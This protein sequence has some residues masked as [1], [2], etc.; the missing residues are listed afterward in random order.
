MDMDAGS[1]NV[2]PNLIFKA[3]LGD[4][5]R[6]GAHA[7]PSWPRRRRV[8]H[9][10]NGHRKGKKSRKDGSDG[11]DGSYSDLRCGDDQ[12]RM[13]Q[14]AAPYDRPPYV[15]QNATDGFQIAILRASLPPALH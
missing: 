9:K 15:T 10:K 5:A 1:S 13:L 12:R 4:G 6:H 11:K 2:N 7:L 8:Q 3:R 14:V